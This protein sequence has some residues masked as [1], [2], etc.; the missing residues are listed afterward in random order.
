MFFSLEMGHPTN[1]VTRTREEHLRQPSDDYF[2][3]PLHRHWRQTPVSSEGAS[4]DSES[5]Q[6]FL[7]S[8]S[9]MSDPLTLAVKYNP[10]V[11]NLV[12][13]IDVL[14]EEPDLSRLCVFDWIAPGPFRFGG[15]KPKSLFSTPFFYYLHA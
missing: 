7:G 15:I 5:R 8:A 14:A 9:H 13:K 6:R 1:I 2:I 3:H 10:K 4:A 11:F 12:T